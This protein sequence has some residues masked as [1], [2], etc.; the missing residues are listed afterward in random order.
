MMR[1]LEKTV[2]LG[3]FGLI[4]SVITAEDAAAFTYAKN[5]SVS[6]FGDICDD[7]DADGGLSGTDFNDC[8]EI[9]Q[10]DGPVGSFSFTLDDLSKGIV[11]DAAFSLTAYRADL[12]RAGGGNSRNEYFGFSLDDFGLGTLF[13]E[14]VA[15]EAKINPWLASSVEANIEKARR[16][17]DSIELSWNMPKVEI[18]PLIQDKSISATFAF[19]DEIN[20]MR[21]VKLSVSYDAT[22]VPVPFGAMMMA[23]GIAALGFAGRRRRRR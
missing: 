8:G 21:D 12:F 6:Y 16:S 15:D 2:V 23:T 20:S 13:D 19:S 17:D 22:P 5:A 3:A 14:T 11:S 1:A 10:N 7:F 4:C 9:V 18:W